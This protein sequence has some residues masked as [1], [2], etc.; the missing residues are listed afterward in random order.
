M[1]VDSPHEPARRDALKEPTS[2]ATSTKQLEVVSW[3]TS[4]S[5]SAAL[6]ELFAT[7][8]QS[9]PGVRAINDTV[10]QRDEQILARKSRFAKPTR[11]PSPKRRD[12]VRC[13]VSKRFV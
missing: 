11:S 3:W 7:F 1:L 9:N 2:P 4:G 5:E 6:N 13:D 8:R 10:A 12:S